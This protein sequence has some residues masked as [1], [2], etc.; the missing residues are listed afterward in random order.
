MTCLRKRALRMTDVSPVYALVARKCWTG[1][2]PVL[3]GWFIGSLRLL[4]H[5]VPASAGAMAFPN[6]LGASKCDRLKAGLHTWKFTARDGAVLIRRR[7]DD[8]WSL[9]ST[10]RYTVAEPH[11]VDFAFQCQAHRPE[12]F[13]QRGY[14]VLFFANYMNDV[15]DVPIHFR[16]VEAPALKTWNTTRIITS[17]STFGVT[18]IRDSPNLSITDAQRMAWS[19]F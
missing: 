3:P 12:L 2:T 8:P 5:V 7:E 4:W 11:A 15:A 17:N 14:A 16:G 1:G 13:G 10:F 6:G 18:I 19:S 9:S